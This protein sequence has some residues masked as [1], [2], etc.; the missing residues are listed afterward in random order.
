MNLPTLIVCLIL[1]LCLIFA[2]RKMLRDK[3]AG[4]H[5][6][7]G[8]CSACPMSDSCRRTDQQNSEPE[9]R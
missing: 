3:K 8:S 2:L 7:G 1:L 5:A 9:I 4:K 6:C